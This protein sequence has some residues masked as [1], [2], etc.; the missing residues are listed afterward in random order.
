M[1]KEVT[2]NI[3]SNEMAAHGLRIHSTNILMTERCVLGNVQRWRLT[4]AVRC[5]MGD[6]YRGREWSRFTDA[7]DEVGWRY[8][9]C[10]CGWW[11][12]PRWAPKA[13]G[14]QKGANTAIPGAVPVPLSRAIFRSPTRWEVKTSRPAHF[15]QRFF[16]PFPMETVRIGA[17]SLSYSARFLTTISCRLFA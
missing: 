9:F 15:L 6:T 17:A 5:H 12:G 2:H 1:K 3:N 11:V 4:E 8:H 16:L 7:A 10:V 13:S 14:P